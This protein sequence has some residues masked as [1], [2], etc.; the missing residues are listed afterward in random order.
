MKEEKIATKKDCRGSP[1]SFGE[2][3]EFSTGIVHVQD[4]V[5]VSIHILKKEDDN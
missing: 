4:H 1:F 5:V 3:L 2:Q